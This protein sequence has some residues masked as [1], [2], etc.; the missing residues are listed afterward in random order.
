MPAGG[1]G[2][3]AAQNLC[4]GAGARAARGAAAASPAYADRRMLYLPSL[5][6]QDCCSIFPAGLR[7]ARCG[8]RALTGASCG[9]N[10]PVR[11]KKNQHTAPVREHCD[12]PRHQKEN[13]F[14][15]AR[16]IDSKVC[17]ARHRQYRHH[18]HHGLIIG[19]WS[20]SWEMPLYEYRLPI[21]IL[22][23]TGAAQG[24]D[25]GTQP[26]KGKGGDRCTQLRRHTVM[27]AARYPVG[28]LFSR[29]LC[30]CL[31]ERRR[32]FCRMHS[33]TRNYGT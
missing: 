10:C 22:H 21:V 13:C 19:A 2:Y 1:D 12:E 33:A 6:R 24:I 29:H 27:S 17:P 7:G 4:D 31:R 3:G 11:K 15:C 5:I 20:A 30:S 9:V 28:G 16:R 25:G 32:T 23:G 26:F 18:D 8:G 14:H